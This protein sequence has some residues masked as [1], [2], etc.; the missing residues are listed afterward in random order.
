MHCIPKI[1]SN[2]SPKTDDEK[3]QDQEVYNEEK[4]KPVVIKTCQPVNS[5]SLVFTKHVMPLFTY[6]FHR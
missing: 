3:F 2:N 6:Y 5:L 1:Q 4:L